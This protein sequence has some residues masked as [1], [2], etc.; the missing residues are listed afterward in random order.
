MTSV[1]RFGMVLFVGQIA[2]YRRDTDMRMKYDR[3]G[4]ALCEE[5]GLALHGDVVCDPHA[6]LV[7]TVRRIV[8][9]GMAGRV[10]A[11]HTAEAIVRELGL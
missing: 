7:E 5:C 6:V 2:R 9:K 8:A 3:N 11:F 1:A 4:R 10:P